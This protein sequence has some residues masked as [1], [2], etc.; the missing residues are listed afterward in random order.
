VLKMERRQIGVDFTNQWRWRRCLVQ[1][2][3]S[4]WCSNGSRR[5]NGKGGVLGRPLS[6]LEA[7]ILRGMEV[8]VVELLVPST[9]VGRG[10][11]GRGGPARVQLRGREGGSDWLR[12]TGLKAAD[13]D[14]RRVEADGGQ[15]RYLPEQGSGAMESGSDPK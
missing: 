14:T 8:A 3:V 13:N 9:E 5:T 7:E 10:K 15:A 12:R 11:R 6:A 1:I 2:P 4:G